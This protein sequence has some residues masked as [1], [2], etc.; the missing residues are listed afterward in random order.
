MKAY[1]EHINLTVTDLDG[2][3]KFFQTAFPHFKVRGGGKRP[4]GLWAHVG[5]D[6]TYVALT[7][8]VGVNAAH[9]YDATGFNHVGFVV[10]DVKDLAARLLNAG[11]T[12]S[13]PIQEQQYRIR[14]YFFDNEGNE[15]EF[16]QYLSEEPEQ[17]NDYSE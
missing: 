4:G 3:I 2:A 10:D 12:R 17:R 13:Y 15:Y 6:D 14:D 7:T 9:N 8:G 11:Y 5:T 16:V 1:M